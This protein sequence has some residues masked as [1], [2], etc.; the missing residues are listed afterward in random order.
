MRIITAG[1]DGYKQQFLR[2]VET[3]GIEMQKSDGI[4]GAQADKYLPYNIQIDHPTAPK[5]SRNGYQMTVFP[6]M[7]GQATVIIK[8]QGTGN[9]GPKRKS[10]TLAYLPGRG[11]NTEHLP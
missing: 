11:K 8:D 6:K 3:P 4:H 7:F 5:T 1:I 10:I 9:I 2:P